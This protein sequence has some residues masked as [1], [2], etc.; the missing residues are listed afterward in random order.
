MSDGMIKNK[1]NGKQVVITEAGNDPK[2]AA[3]VY[4]TATFLSEGKSIYEGVKS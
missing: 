2:G 4:F 3:L 1:R